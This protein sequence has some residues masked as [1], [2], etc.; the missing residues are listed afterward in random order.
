MTFGLAVATTAFAVGQAIGPMHTGVVT[1]LTHSVS[2]GLYT[3]P[4]LLMVATLSA[5]AQPKG[6]N[7]RLVAITA[8]ISA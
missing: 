4:A 2:A 5:L 7:E 8:L 1:D 3:S 6:L